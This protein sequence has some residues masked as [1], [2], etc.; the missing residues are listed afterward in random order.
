MTAT[1]WV[2]GTVTA[3]PGKAGSVRVW[4]RSLAEVVVRRP[5]VPG[6][7]HSGGVRQLVLPLVAVEFVTSFLVSSMVPPPLRPAHAVLEAL[8]IVGGLALVAALIR[9]PHQVDAE[10][11]VLRTGFL[12]E[13]VLPRSAVRSVS[14]VIRTVDGRGPRPVPGE[15]DAVACSVSDSLD[16]AVHLDPPVRLDLGAA[17][18]VDARTV[19][20]SAD[21]PAAF[22]AALRAAR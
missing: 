16:V 12:G 11:L 7:R 8:L 2:T 13:V 14:P 9:H 3:G 20:A 21:F 10:R 6:V 18:V 1:E 19:Y 17:G 22:S 5:A 4:V 15:P